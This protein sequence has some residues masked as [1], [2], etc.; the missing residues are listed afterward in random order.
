[1]EYETEA[2]DHEAYLAEIADEAEID[3]HCDAMED[4]E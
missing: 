1:M 3:S 2:Y 4:E